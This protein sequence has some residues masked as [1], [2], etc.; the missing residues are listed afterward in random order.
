MS[1]SSFAKHID[2]LFRITHT[3]TFNIALQALQL[4]YQVSISSPLSSSSVGSSSASGTSS[5]TSS[6]GDRFYRALYASLL[7]PRLATTSKQAMYLNLLY[8]AVKSDEDDKR[9]K[10]FVKR[11][12]QT[13]LHAEPPWIC[14]SL[15]LLGEVSS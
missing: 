7:D 3:S 13:L 10:A 2:T 11:F 12:A 8:K 5:L 6:I 15:F 1:L 9:T 4:I 14:G